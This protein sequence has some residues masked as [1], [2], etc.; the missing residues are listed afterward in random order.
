M[1]SGRLGRFL[2]PST[3][4]T[5][6]VAA[7]IAVLIALPAAA[8][9]TVRVSGWGG[10]DVAIV[11]ELIER[12]VRPAVEPQGIRV[13]YEP[14]ADAYDTYI[15]NALSAGTAP[16]VFY[17]DIFWSEGL[18]RAGQLEPLNEYLD[19]SSVLKAEHIIP[20]L[21]DAFTLDGK[22]YGIPKDFNTLALFYN[23]DLF[24]LAGV[25]YP[26]ENDDWNTLTDKLRRVA[27]LDPDI[28]G[29][30]LAPE[31]ARFGAFALATGWEPFDANGHT[32]VLDP[33]FVEA[34]KWYTGLLSGR[35]GV[36][37]Q[38][39]G[40]GWGGGAL[41][42]EQVAAAIE[43]A[44]ILGFLR[45]AAPNMA[46]GA[47]P[48]PKHPGSGQRG[49]LIF[50]VSW[51]INARSQVKDEAFKVLEALTS[52]EAQQWILERG[53]ALPSRAALVNNPYFAQPDPEAQANLVVF[54]GASDGHV[55][56]FKFLHYGGDWMA[57]INDALTAVLLGELDADAA[58]REAQQRLDALTGR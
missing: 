21:L 32:N 27:A 39:V 10:T 9:T 48:L 53:L 58:L 55:H 44:W 13:V 57:P 47:A 24:D 37:P 16:D 56:P 6:I 12:F 7:L 11:E 30:A 36:H 50:T 8:Q 25:P 49:N 40:Q 18:M 22:I 29:L 2:R 5:G 23:K 46:F 1:Q 15:V 14:I 20:D 35:S 17:V 3:F 19:R 41:S 26:D 54:Q 28:Y 38:D 52:P 42:T 31:Y 43:G 51:S 45:D 34:F 4:T 33:R